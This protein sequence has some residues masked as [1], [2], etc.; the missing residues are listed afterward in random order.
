MI[1]DGILADGRSALRIA[2]IIRAHHAPEQLARLVRRLDS[3]ESAFLIHVNL[4]TSEHVF[5]EMQRLLGANERVT[6]LP[7][8]R[9]YY[10]GF[11]LVRAALIGVEASASLRPAPDYTLLLSGQDYPIKPLSDIFAFFERGEGRSFVHHFPLPSPNWQREDGG[12][13]RVRYWYFERLAIR[14]RVLRVPVLERKFPRGF[15]PYGGSFLWALTANAIEYVERQARMDSEIL[16]FFRHVKYPDELFFQTLLLNSPLADE[17][18][19]EELHFID[20]TTG[21]AHPRTLTRSDFEVLRESPKLFARKFDA[22]VDES[23]LDEI[24]E[25]LLHVANDSR[26]K[27]AAESMAPSK[28]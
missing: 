24:D 26:L 19:N 10:G 28:L 3:P 17:V 18:A 6:W 5:G 9:C 23:I 7:R 1:Y 27:P 4:R 25:Q 21:S 12:L 13:D 11:S 2:Y 15:R 20:W 8:I 22:R 14:T 16:R